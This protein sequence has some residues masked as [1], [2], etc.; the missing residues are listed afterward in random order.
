MQGETMSPSGNPLILIHEGRNSRIYHQPAGPGGRS[1]VIKVSNTEHPS[2]SQLIRLKNEYEFT[3]NLAIAG[4][5]N[6]IAQTTLGDKP[7]LVL[8][9]IDG[10]TLRQS[11]VERKQSLIDFLHVAIRIA[12]TLAEVH[13]QHIIHMNVNSDNILVVPEAKQIKLIDFGLASRLD[14]L[15]KYLGNPERLPGTLAYI[16]PE[17]TGR[18]NRV[19]DY[20]TDLYSLGVTFYEILTGRLPFESDDPLA[21]VHAHMAKTPLPVSVLD[22]DVPPLISDMVMK[23]LAKNAE[24]RY[25]SAFG[26]KV[27]LERCLAWAQA[28]GSSADHSGLDFELGREDHSG[29]FHISEKLFG[30][31]DEIATLLAAFDRAAAG[32]PEL[33]LVTG[34]AGVG[35]SALVAEIHKPVTR[36]RGYFISGKFDQYQQNQ[37]YAAF[38]QAFEDFADLLLSESETTLQQWRGKILAAVNGNGTV[39]T[40]VMPGLEKIIG[41]QPAVPILAG[42]E[43]RNRFHLTFQN[44]MK[45]ISTAEHPLVLFIDD[46]QW[47]DLA[48]L[49]LFK[50]LLTGEK[51]AYSLMIGSYRDSEVDLAHP[52]KMAL[53]DIAGKGVAARTILLENLQPED[54]RRLIQESLSASVDDARVLTGLVYKK[55]RGNAFFTRQFLQTLNEEGLL[56]F[57]FNSHRWTWDIA[58]LEARNITDNVVDLMSGKMKK[59]SHETARL[60]QLAACMGNEFD[61][62]TLVLIGRTTGPA[63]LKLLSDALTEGLLIP[64][65]S[66]YKIPEMA[67]RARFSFLH[68]RV[69][70]AAYA[71]IPPIERQ[72]VHLEIGRLLLANTPETDLNQRVFSIVQHFNHSGALITDPAERLT[73][74]ELNIKAA[75]LA[76]GAAAF[77][78]AQEYLETALSLMPP[79]AW[80]DRYDLMLRLYSQSSTV[81]SLTG[82]FEQMERAVQITEMH[83]RTM[84]E[85][86]QAKQAKI[87]SLHYRGNYAEAIELGLTFIQAMGV[88]INRNPSPEEAFK[89]LQETAEWLTEERIEHLIDLPEAPVEVGVILEV[90]SVING[91]LFNTNMNLFFALVSQITRLCIEKGLTHWAPVNLMTFTSLLS[92]AL[93]DIPKA[94]HLANATMQLLEKRYRSDNPIS[95]LSLILGGFIR[96]RHDHVKN[97]IP[98]LVDGVQKGLATGNFQFA[99]YCAWWQTWH[100]LFA[101]APLPEVEAVTRQSLE[102][103]KKA[104]MERLHVWC[105][106]VRQVV[107]NLQGK[108]KIPWILK[109]EAY[110][111]QEELA[112]AFRLN[113]LADVF[114]IFFYNG[115]LNYLFG[116]WEPA[117]SFFREAES[118]MLNGVGQY[119]I[120]LFYLYDTLANAALSDSHPAD[121]TLGVLQRINRNLAQ[122]EVWVRYAPMNHQHKKDLMEAEKA[123]LEGRYWE[124]ATLYEKAAQGARDNGFLNEEAL[125]CELCGKFWIEHGRREIARTFLRKA[126]D[127]YRR[128]GASAKAEQL[129]TAFGQSLGKLHP[130]PWDASHVLEPHRPDDQAPSASWLD[131]GSLLK[132]TRTLSQTVELPDLLAKMIEILLENAG[133]ER[134]LVLYRE[135]DGWFIRACGQVQNPAVDTTLHLPVSKATNISLNIFNYVVNSGKAMV[136]EN[137]S[138]DPQFGA[139]PYLCEHDVKS[140][141]C[142]PICHKGELNLVLYLENNLAECAF[143]E[144][145]LE[146]L[147][148]LSGQMAISLENALIYDSLRSSIAERKRAEETLKVNEERLRLALEATYDGIW[149]WNVQTGQVYFSPRYYT[150]MGY[151]P[152]EFPATYENWRAKLHPDDMEQTE[153]A[154]LRAVDQN[155]RFAIEFR[156]K[157]KNGEWRWLQSRGKVAETDSAGKALRIAGSHT[158]I[159]ER[160]QAEETLRNYERIVSTSQDLIAL[161]NRDYVYEAVNDSLLTAHKKTREELVGRTIP[162]VFGESVFREAL[163]PRLEQA[164][165]GATVHYQITHDFSGS[166]RR[167]MD[168][169]YFPVFDETGKVTGVVL[170]ARDI[171]ETRKLEEQLVQSQKIESIG[172]LAGGVA[173][174]INNPINGIMN[175]AQLILDRTGEDH[176]ANEYAGEIL[177]ETQRIAG[178][179]RNL[180]TFARHE[181]QSHSPAQLADVISAVL[182]LVQTVM[183]HDQIT[184]EL[185]IPEDLPNVKCRSQQI[186][187]VLMNLM[188]NARDALNERYSGYSPDKILRIAAEE[189]IKHGRRFIR[190]T[191]EDTGTG[192]PAEIRD[193]IFDPFFTTKPKE[194]G[195]G[196]GLSISYGI[197]RDHGGELGVE[198]VP[199]RYTRFHMDLPVDNGWTLAEN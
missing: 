43:N 187:Q 98:I 109:G 4:V 62:L 31:S 114:R 110:D 193:R 163:K 125:A 9:Y 161:I 85:T 77:R 35:K 180:L 13:K 160:K 76:Y 171:T 22:P 63:A 122:M 157:A 33:L 112:S 165:S 192:I 106:L 6:A 143:T 174:E 164:L 17:Q 26:L 100:L 175:Y 80:N 132:A 170:N 153:R 7:A 37:P 162:E 91:P 39:L 182:S 189:I 75:D 190:T 15:T 178:I 93:D 90:A 179:V 197:V 107:L 86:A 69:Q 50:E 72:T 130:L 82:D 45:A 136:L 111:E 18:M 89:Y 176:P 118:Y 64:M 87:R 24:D 44:F 101:G 78:S 59:L 55:T 95:P 71:Q 188:T 159:T 29:Q 83:A 12:R 146:F 191:V 133:A 99:G 67:I 60:L 20:R 172:T 134:V 97:T 68:D 23:L 184:L 126:H 167:I 61:L 119:L 57:D 94:R 181:K 120:P 70:Q 198:S 137:A 169:T 155:G 34:R 66:Y 8:E 103:C 123:R 81:F 183:R 156:F 88:T 28:P 117:V 14:S 48:S 154:V 158:D 2:P 58:Q 42:Q 166:G 96:H 195:T 102:T 142:L 79:D 56:L 152:N 144:D 177:Y 116:W 16:S 115:W 38:T 74:A 150:M 27:D 129:Q 194:T 113:D 51:I 173:H 139:E 108:S 140:V 186:Q 73:V 40:E 65:D 10:Q 131:I 199:D 124:A 138:R 47:A 46:W 149:D 30:R 92:G 168:T 25:Q 32:S 104:Q 84:A 105:S 19:V 1:V 49:E 21:L 11:F 141:L 121:E 151:E 53:E 148:L 127:A 135:D 185:A 3:K 36:E 41:R 147:R 54:V 145:R 5:R 52:F 128:W 196:L